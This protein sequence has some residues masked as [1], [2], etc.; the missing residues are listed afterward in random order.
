MSDTAL[1]DSYYI[2]RCGV[3]LPES[4]S[5]NGI[6]RAA[7]SGDKEILT[8]DSAILQLNDSCSRLPHAH[9]QRIAHAHYHDNNMYVWGAG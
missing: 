6:K 9:A 7:C 2:V 4:C 8:L 5:N 1:D 3:L